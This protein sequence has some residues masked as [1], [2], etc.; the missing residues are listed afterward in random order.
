MLKNS[1]TSGMAA[2]NQKD[3]RK[4]FNDL[5]NGFSFSY[6]KGTKN[7]S[8]YLILSRGDPKKDGE[9]SLELWDL[10]EQKLLHDWGI[11]LKNFYAVLNNA[12]VDRGKS[13]S[14]YLN[15]PLMLDDG[16]IV[17]IFWGNGK[18]NPL[19]KISLNGLIDRIN[20]DFYFHHSIEI[21][22]QDYL[23]VPIREKEKSGE[24]FAEEG[25]AILDKNLNIIK[26]FFLS[27]IFDK[28]NLNYLIYSKRV[29]SDPFH[30]NDVQPIVNPKE[31]SIVLLSLRSLSSIIAYD[32]KEEKVLWVLQGYANR[33]HDVDILNENGSYISIFDNNIA[34]GLDS[35]GNKFLEINGLPNLKNKENINTLIYSSISNHDAEKKLSLKSENFN[36]LE[37]IKRPKTITGGQS[38]FIKENNSIFIEESNYGRLIEI[39]RNNGEVLWTYINRNDSNK[40]YYRMSWS[41]RLKSIPYKFN[42][43]F[44]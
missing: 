24:R 38:E 17:T 22:S 4:R 21:D 35:L 9:P 26:K 25:F 32:F 42:K 43:I 37:E 5:K 8:G 13:N 31:T 39:D 2:A 23:Y 1:S 34:K 6:E 12:K 10:N 3:T 30:L 29:T 28:S 18:D 19:L 16:S 11:N 15:H 40:I 14:V 33:Q 36:F 44:N 41:R 7:K 20:T 27:D